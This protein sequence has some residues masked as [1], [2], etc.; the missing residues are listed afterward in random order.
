MPPPVSSVG[1]NINTGGVAGKKVSSVAELKAAC[2]AAERRQK[3]KV[4]EKLNPQ[5]LPGKSQQQQQMQT[6][7]KFSFFFRAVR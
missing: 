1:I 2:E 3:Q 6:R 4:A 5:R 7:R